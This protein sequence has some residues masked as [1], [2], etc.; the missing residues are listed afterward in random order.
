MKR[1]PLMHGDFYGDQASAILIATI[2]AG[3][4]STARIKTML[5]EASVVTKVLYTCHDR[6]LKGI[7]GNV[8]CFARRV[9]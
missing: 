2:P 4:K 3:F 5:A 8:F 9:R 7:S 6:R 1:S